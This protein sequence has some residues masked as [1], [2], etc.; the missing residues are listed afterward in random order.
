MEN[1]PCSVNELLV[2]ITEAIEEKDFMRL[3]RLERVCSSW[4]QPN[5]ESD[6]QINLI[7]TVAELLYQAS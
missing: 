7:R 4:L 1:D 2:A 3:E 5:Y 6:A